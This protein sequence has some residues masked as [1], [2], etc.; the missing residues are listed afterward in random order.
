MLIA[1][2]CSKT[3]AENIS[4]QACECE[5][6]YYKELATAYDTLAKFLDYKQVADAS[7][8]QMYYGEFT[9]SITLKNE[10]CLNSLLP[11]VDEIKAKLNNDQEKQALS[12]SISVQFVRCQEQLGTEFKGSTQVQ[13][14]QKRIQYINQNKAPM[15]TS[16]H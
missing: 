3:D 11:K 15:P 14:L 13:N 4:S 7:I 10:N 8:Y 2:S 9:D 5:A 6:N 12:D 16:N 1:A